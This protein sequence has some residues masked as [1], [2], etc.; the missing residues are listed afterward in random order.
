MARRV[1]CRRSS[2]EQKKAGSYKEPA[3]SGGKTGEEARGEN[4]FAA[5][6]GKYGHDAEHRDG[7]QN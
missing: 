2:P 6:G 1:L 3:K 4:L 5:G 7:C